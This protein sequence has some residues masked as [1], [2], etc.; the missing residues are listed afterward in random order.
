MTAFEPPDFTY[1]T[2]LQ[3]NPEIYENTLTDSAGALPINPTFNSVRAPIV[4]TDSI[5]RD[6]SNTINLF[7]AFPSVT[8]I[9]IGLQGMLFIF[10]EWVIAGAT[11]SGAG[12]P[13]IGFGDG[14]N[15]VVFTGVNAYIYGSSA[16][17]MVSGLITDTV[18]RFEPTFTRLTTSLFEVVQGAVTTIEATATTTN[19]RNSISTIITTPL[20]KVV[21]GA[22]TTIEAT[23]AY[24]EFRNSSYFKITAPNIYFSPLGTW[25]AFSATNIRTSFFNPTLVEVYADTNCD[26]YAPRV[27]MK[28]A[29]ASTSNGFDFRTNTSDP[30]ITT[31]S[32][33]ASGGTTANTGTLT[34]TAAVQRL[35]TATLEVGNATPTAV[36][37]KT[38]T[39]APTTTTSSI[40]ASG[41]TTAGTGTIVIDAAFLQLDTIRAGTMDFKTTTQT[42]QRLT[43]GNNGT[44]DGN[45]TEFGPPFFSYILT[46]GGNFNVNFAST[47][48][49]TNGMI[50]IAS[51]STGAGSLTMPS[52]QQRSGFRFYLY[53]QST[54]TQTIQ[55]TGNRFT[56]VGLARAGQASFTMATNTARLI[57][58]SSSPFTNEFASGLNTNMVV[59]TL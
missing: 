51:A 34:T 30:S 7:D 43:N 4:Y 11:I 31:S 5:Q 18:M 46:A 27:S 24:T 17:E 1:F 39:A 58:S 40:V 53:N 37:F 50:I 6:T 9:I 22:L 49:S 12:L 2:G 19:L 8:S 59:F 3:F 38:N 21:Q 32:I 56:G 23:S 55:T 29:G 36:N 26:F 47:A 35:N 41:G 57:I 20:F 44:S 54:F 25:N 52:T 15:D 10:G 45:Y 48:I 28:L 14:S 42:I 33:V 13:A 16:I